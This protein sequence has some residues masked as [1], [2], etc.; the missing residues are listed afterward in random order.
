MEWYEMTNQDILD[1]KDDWIDNYSSS[2]TWEEYWKEYLWWKTEKND[3][4]RNYK[5]NKDITYKT[6]GKIKSVSLG[7]EVNKY[8]P[9][10]SLNTSGYLIMNWDE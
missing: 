7:Y 10:F 2:M 3:K 5:R 8:T 9:T 1:S 6:V 4:Q